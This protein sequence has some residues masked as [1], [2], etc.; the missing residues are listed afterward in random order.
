M[1]NLLPNPLKPILNK[2][3]SSP[4]F[5]TF[6]ILILLLRVVV[7]S[8]SFGAVVFPGPVEH[9]ML[10]APLWGVSV[11]WEDG[12]TDFA[13]V[14]DD[15]GFLN[16]V[17]H[18][19]GDINFGLF[20]RFFLGG[21]ISWV[22]P[23]EGGPYGLRGLVVATAN[24]DRLFFLELTYSDPFFSVD[25][26]VELPEDPGTLDFLSP[27]PQGQ[28]QLALSLPGI[29][30]LLI[31][32]QN[33]GQWII[34]QTLDTGDE[35]WSLTAIDLDD[36]QVLELVTAN[37]GVLSGTLGI[38]GQQPDGSYVLQSHEQLPGK[39]RQVGH[40]DFN[41]DGVQE[42]IVS[43]SDLNQLNIFSGATGELIVLETIESSLPSDF[44]QVITLPGG[45]WGLLSSV[46]DR[47]FMDFFR[48][49][50]GLWVHEESYY[51]G[52]N[53][54]MTF[55]S[56]LNGDGVND[57]LCLG[58]E[59]Y[60]FSVLLG[61]TSS[62]FWG[63]PA[64]PLPPFPGS[65]VLADFDGDGVSELVVG[66]FGDNV[67]SHYSFQTSGG[68]FSPPIHQNL[69]FFPTYLAAGDFLGDAALELV[70]LHASQQQVLLMTHDPEA[71]FVPNTSIDLSSNASRTVAA[72]IDDDGNTDIVL[73]IPGQ[74]EVHILYGEGDGVF[75]SPVIL[76]FPIG[77]FDAVALH[78]DE[79]SYLDLVVSDGV[80]RV[81]AV[82]NIDGHS[83][84]AP[85]AT[86]ANN[87]AKFLAVA[88]LDGDNDLD[89]V[90]A[91]TFSESLTVVE[92]LGDGSLFRRIG[93][94]NMGGQPA[95]LHCSDMNGDGIPDLVAQLVG[96]GGL[97]VVM[98]DVVWGYVLP[99]QYQTSSNVV[100][101]QVADFSQDGPTDVLNL[102]TELSLGII[103]VNTPRVLV[104][105]DP[106]ALSLSC[107]AEDFSV[108]ILP[109]RPGPWELALGK[110]G[111]WQILAANGQARTG[112][113]DF[114]GQGW[115]L[116]F[117]R[118]DAGFPD[119]SMRLKLTVGTNEQEEVLTLALHEDCFA[120]PGQIPKVRWLDQ[121]WPNPFNPRV[122][123]RI[124][125]DW[126]AFVDVA[127]FDVAGHRMATL[128]EGNLP[129]G[130]HAISW[131]GMRQGQSAPAG[132]YF[133]RIRSD[134]A[135]LSR[136]IMLL[137]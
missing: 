55:A 10:A 95:S 116:A 88:D 19:H 109:D 27:G 29:D 43:Y 44:F 4:V 9:P 49:D 81:W 77:V 130:I 125:L 103:L 39:V 3:R 11:P 54:V 78:L 83:F 136:K 1:V 45:A 121:P 56:D 108:N 20:D 59:Q 64:I 127:V 74:K 5:L 128:L 12:I 80:S 61:K 31:L 97:R 26:L 58:G 47:G 126:P 6:F 13:V 48:L 94:L 42:L 16:L 17:Y 111:Q 79:D 52:C 122:H 67:L 50:Q 41:L 62:F 118:E 7:P 38:Y 57:I 66:S 134:S 135:L 104:A 2:P 30:Q 14:G 15:D 32:R 112:F 69:G 22:G 68:L 120:R 34:H 84:G 113:L 102:D 119:S 86:E 36:N 75:S 107:T 24:P 96:D 92:N 124:Q 100:A 51:V 40:E 98:A 123:G 28:S 82:T 73:T 99:L 101:M 129:A 33:E 105:V 117:S 71:G 63:Y 21:S 131:D 70:A 23:W 46:Q 115:I 60:K 106:T 72:D 37:Q 25:Q 87:G 65:T 85:V 90:V 53:P 35:P 18:V 133:L 76:D 110:P 93:S 132:L 114:D 8:D 137:K 91:N 89:L